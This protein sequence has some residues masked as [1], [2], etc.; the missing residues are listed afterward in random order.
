MSQRH[1]M[2]AH[3]HLADARRIRTA[4]ANPVQRALVEGDVNGSENSAH[5]IYAARVEA[6][7][8]NGMA[9]QRRK[10]FPRRTPKMSICE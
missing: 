10:F 3:G 5:R 9:A 6:A 8:R 4:V 2:A 1:Q 7:Y